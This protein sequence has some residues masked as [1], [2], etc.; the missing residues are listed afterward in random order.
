MRVPILGGITH[1]IIRKQLA[2]YVSKYRENYPCFGRKLESSDCQGQSTYPIA[3][4]RNQK[5]QAGERINEAKNKNNKSFKK[6]NHLKI[7]K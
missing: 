7:K 6:V 4:V 2:S 3:K 1:L 5:D